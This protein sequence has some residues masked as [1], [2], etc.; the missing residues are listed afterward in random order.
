MNVNKV[1]ESGL[2]ERY[3]SNPNVPNQTNAE[4]QWKVVV[5]LKHF[6][7]NQKTHVYLAAATHD[8]AELVTGD[9]PSPAKRMQ[10]ALK[11]LLDA[12]EDEIESEWG[13]KYNLSKEEK[14]KIKICDVLEGMHYCHKQ[15]MQGN[16][17]ALE[18]FSKWA[19]YYLALPTYEKNELTNNFA[20]T[21]EGEVLDQF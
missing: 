1:L 21:L 17:L 19:Q 3:H 9:S 7:P 4:H 10:P 11:I 13:I 8:A 5:L 14:A 2:V 18:P 16:K 6:Y 20:E 12:M 15:I